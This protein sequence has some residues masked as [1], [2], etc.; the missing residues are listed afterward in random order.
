MKL[1]FVPVGKPA[2]P[3]P[4][5]PEAF[6]WSMTCSRVGLAR[7]GSSPTPGSRRCCGRCPASTSA[8]AAATRTALRFN[9]SAVVRALRAHFRSSRILSTVSGVR[10]S[11]NTWSTII[12]GAPVQAARHSSS[13]LRK[14]RPSAVLSSELDAEFLLGV[15]HQ[16][17]AAAQHAGDVGADADVMAAAGMRSR[18]S[19]RSSPPRTPGSAAAPGTR[20]PHPSARRSGSRGSAPARRAAPRCTAERCRPGGNFAT[21]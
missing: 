2:P 11:W 20:R 4:R 17:L 5:S 12:I 15:R 8:R 7:S 18:T 10:C 9:L 6:T 14:M 3:R 1:H 21:Q 19:S 13:R 16:L